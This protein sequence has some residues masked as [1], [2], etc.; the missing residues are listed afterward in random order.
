MD[1]RTNGWMDLCYKKDSAKIGAT[2]AAHHAQAS[3]C[4]AA[5]Y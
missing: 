1:E 2:V 5:Y 3:N 4:I